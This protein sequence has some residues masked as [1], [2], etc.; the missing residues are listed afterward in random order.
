[1][2][3]DRL[4]HIRAHRRRV[5]SRARRQAD[6]GL[7]GLAA[8]LQAEVFTETEI[9]RTLPRGRGAGHRPG[10]G[11]QEADPA[12]RWRVEDEGAPALETSPAP[13]PPEGSREPARHRHVRQFTAARAIG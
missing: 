9:G 12:L 13:P 7:R 3:P 4:Q 11:F 8:L 5:F 10:P 6:A 2:T 1:M